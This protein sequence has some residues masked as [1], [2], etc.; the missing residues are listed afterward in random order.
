MGFDDEAADRL[1]VHEAG[2]AAHMLQ[3]PAAKVVFQLRSGS[4]M[5]HPV[6]EHAMGQRH[7]GGMPPPANLA[8]NDSGIGAD[9]L[10]F[11][12]SHPHVAGLVMSLVIL[13]TAQ[14]AAIDAHA[15][16]IGDRF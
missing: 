12:Q 13:R 11:Q 10:A 8:V 9:V 14:R 5:H 4:G 2:V 3:Q 16:Q 15:L 7:A 6:V 1:K